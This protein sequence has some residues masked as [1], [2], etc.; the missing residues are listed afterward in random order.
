MVYGDGTLKFQNR[1]F[2]LHKVE[3]K[4]KILEEAHNTLCLVHSGGTKMYKDLPQYFWWDNIKKEI[5][6]CLDKYLSF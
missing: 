5:T 1:L 4:I 6:E 2:V 3:L